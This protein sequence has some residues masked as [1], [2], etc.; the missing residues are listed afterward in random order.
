MAGD[1]DTKAVSYGLLS[2]ILSGFT[3]SVTTEAIAEDVALI[4]ADE[5]EEGKQESEGDVQVINAAE[6]KL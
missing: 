2:G 1:E 5:P 3:D 4:R 6:Y